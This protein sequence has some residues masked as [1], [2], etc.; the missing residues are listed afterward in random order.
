ML[1]FARGK[2]NHLNPHDVGFNAVPAKLTKIERK[3]PHLRVKISER[4]LL[5]ISGI[6]IIFL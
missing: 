1:I 3:T 4:N 2:K 6:F 5:N